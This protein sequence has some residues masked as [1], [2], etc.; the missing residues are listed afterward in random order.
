MW[1]SVTLTISRSCED[2]NYAQNFSICERN[3]RHYLSSINSPSLCVVRNGCTLGILDYITPCRTSD[4][5]RPVLDR[6]WQ[7]VLGAEFSESE[8]MQMIELLSSSTL[9]ERGAGDRAWDTLASLKA[10]IASLEISRKHSADYTV[11]A[12]VAAR[13]RI[14]GRLWRELARESPH[15]VGPDEEE[16]IAAKIATHPAMRKEL[17]K[18]NR[19]LELLRG[20]ATL[21]TG[22]IG[23]LLTI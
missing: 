16:R 3:S 19:Q 23:I 22:D 10:A 12:A 8:V 9:D 18:E 13:D 5:V 15:G 11:S 14:D 6:L 20:R 2:I 4:L 21:T 1:S 17:E 7:H